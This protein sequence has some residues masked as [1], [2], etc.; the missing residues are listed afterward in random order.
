VAVRMAAM[1]LLARNQVTES[2]REAS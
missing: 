1:D 2:K